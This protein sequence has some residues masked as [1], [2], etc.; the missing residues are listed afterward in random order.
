MEHFVADHD[1]GCLCHQKFMYEYVIE[2]LLVRIY[3]LRVS[4]LKDIYGIVSIG[5]LA[6]MLSALLKLMIYILFV[7]LILYVITC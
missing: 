3:M 6:Y 2:H 4:W 5:L 7:P 1:I